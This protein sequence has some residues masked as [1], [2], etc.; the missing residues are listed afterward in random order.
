MSIA[1]VSNQRHDELDNMI[2]GI[3]PF[4]PV[5]TPFSVVGYMGVSM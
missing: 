1:V 2:L 4:N 3:L 5:L